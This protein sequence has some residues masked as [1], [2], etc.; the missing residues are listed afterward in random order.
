MKVSTEVDFGEGFGFPDL[1]K[2]LLNAR[3]GMSVID[4]DII[5]CSIINIYLRGRSKSPDYDDGRGCRGGR[6][7][8]EGFCKVFFNLYFQLNHYQI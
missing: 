1:V 3:Q 4:H 2:G 7:S 5:Y 6:S 8:N